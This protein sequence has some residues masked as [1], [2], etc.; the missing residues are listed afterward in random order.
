MLNYVVY[1][2]QAVQK[3]LLCSVSQA[4]YF[5]LNNEKTSVWWAVTVEKASKDI[6]SVE[7]FKE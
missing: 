4:E 6:Y 5:R 7:W 1:I 2:G 3:R